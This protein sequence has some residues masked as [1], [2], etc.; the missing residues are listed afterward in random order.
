MRLSFR[1]R[2]VFIDIYL[3]FLISWSTMFY[4]RVVRSTCSSCRAWWIG[5]FFL[6]LLLSSRVLEV[7]LGLKSLSWKLY[8]SLPWL[9]KRLMTRELCLSNGWSLIYT[10][11]SCFLIY[12]EKDDLFESIEDL[13]SM[14]R[15]WSVAY[16]LS[17]LRSK[18]CLSFASFMTLWRYSFIV[19]KLR[20]RKLFI[21]T[22]LDLL[23]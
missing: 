19:W 1:A 18:F 13:P 14:V 20:F 9:L 23:I 10:L 4:L 12:G 17:N 8:F 16:P 7:R 11:G 6:L 5:P 21:E 22:W 15:Y 2:V 3:Y